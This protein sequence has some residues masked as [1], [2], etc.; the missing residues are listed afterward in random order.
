[1]G[2]VGP[3]HPVGLSL[4]VELRE[5]TAVVTVGGELEFGTAS[6]LRTLLL[7][8]AQ[9]STDA[10]VLDLER[11]TFLDSS[12]I[13]LLLQAKQ[14]FEAQGCEFVLRRPAQPIARVL[15][16]AGVAPMFRIE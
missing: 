11:V 13:S 15:E 2:P 10:V 4:A 9:G 16:L 14:R 12:G 8:F 1:M 5:Q 7:E 6:P 3:V